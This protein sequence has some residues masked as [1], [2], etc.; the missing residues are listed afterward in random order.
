MNEVTVTTAKRRSRTQHSQITTTIGAIVKEKSSKHAVKWK[1]QYETAL[2]R[3]WIL[4]RFHCFATFCFISI[5]FF[6]STAAVAS[7]LSLSHTFDCVSIVTQLHTGFS[8]YKR[9]SA[10]HPHNTWFLFETF[11]QSRALNLS[12]ASHSMVIFLR[13]FRHPHP[14]ISL[15]R[16]STLT[17]FIHCCYVLL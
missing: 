11:A 13:V 10:F 12:A 3:R 6:L 9:V 16:H 17:H 4:S 1:L 2:S 8:I 5:R 7:P 15:Y 14:L